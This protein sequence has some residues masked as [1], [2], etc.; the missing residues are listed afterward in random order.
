MWVISPYTKK[1]FTAPQMIGRAKFNLLPPVPKTEEDHDA[2]LE[3][4][5]ARVLADALGWAED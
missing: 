4:E 1:R 5:K 2:E 3:A